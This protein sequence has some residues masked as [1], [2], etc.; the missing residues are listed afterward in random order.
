MKI[1]MTR[2]EYQ[3]RNYSFEDIPD[4][5][6]LAQAHKEML[7]TFFSYLIYVIIILSVSYYFAAQDMQQ[8]QYLF[9]LPRYLTIMAIIAVLG[10]FAFLLSPT[11]SLRL[12]TLKTKTIRAAIRTRGGNHD[13][14]LD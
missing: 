9:G 6:R 2:E 7:V 5:P 13:G 14:S 1:K 3:S 12:K 8:M 4:D 10:A 11:G